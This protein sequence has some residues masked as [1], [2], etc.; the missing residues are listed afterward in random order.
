MVSY[1]KTS[2]KRELKN[3]FRTW[4]IFKVVT[5]VW[6]EFDFSTNDV[7][8]FGPGLGHLSHSF[9]DGIKGGLVIVDFNQEVL[10]FVLKTFPETLKP[11]AHCFD[12][13][14]FPV[15]EF[16]DS[17]DFVIDTHVIE[18]LASPLEHLEDIYSVLKPGG[19]CF[20]STP[21]L[22]SLNALR[23]GESWVGYADPTHVSLLT[24]KQ[25]FELVGECGFEIIHSGTS[26]SSVREAVQMGAVKE[27]IFNSSCA[28]DGM[29]FL[30]R[31]P[32]S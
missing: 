24:F 27:L 26:I 9:S 2:L 21:N 17:Y 30:I 13:N 5:E 18:H 23:D 4:I 8:E 7:I 16:I 14:H 6:K 31:R 32:L 12:L 3:R 11:V 28:G 1:I 22:S 29:N 10:D 20:L 15:S 19:F 25:L